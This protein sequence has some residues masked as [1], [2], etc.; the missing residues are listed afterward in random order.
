M[1]YFRIPY[2]FNKKLFE[3]IDHEFTL[4]QD[5]DWI[6]FTD[7]DTAFLY[8]D[9][10]HKIQEYINHFPG[11]GMLVCY[12]RSHYE[13]QRPPFLDMENDSLLYHKHIASVCRKEY[14]LDV[15]VLNRPISGHLMVIKKSIWLKIRPEVIRTALGKNILGVDTK[16][17]NALIKQGL[18]IIL[19]G[20]LYVLHYLRFAEGLNYTEHIS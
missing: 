20:G 5:D 7:G 13:C 11:A 18:P 12:A 6:C 2:A 9:F 8:A 17:S 16:I 14:S 19:M 4:V 1:L 15:Q 10:G 3:A